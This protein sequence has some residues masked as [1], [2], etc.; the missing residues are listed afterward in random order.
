MSRF[1]MSAYIKT[2]KKA[3]LN[4]NVSDVKFVEDVFNP[5][6]EA[7]NVKDKTGAPLAL[8]KT[9]V[10]RLLA[11]KDDV[12][13]AMRNALAIFNLE[14][15]LEDGFDYLVKDVLDEN[16]ISAVIDLI[17]EIIK[18]DPVVSDEVKS[19]LDGLKNDTV[20]FLIYTFLEAVKIDNRVKTEKRIIWEKGNNS[21]EVISGDIFKF[22][23]G[24]RSVKKKN[25]VCIPVN[26]TFETKITT[27]T[28][29]EPKPLVSENTLHG[30]WLRHWMESGNTIKE[31]DKRIEGNIRLQE[32]EATGK[33][34]A[35]NGKELCYPIGSIVNIETN[36]AVYYLLAI[37]DF[38]K[39]NNARSEQEKIKTAL[40]KLLE[41]YDCKGQGYDLYLPLMGTGRSRAG[42]SH[43]ESFDL[44]KKVLLD[45]K[46]LIQGH[47]TIVAEPDVL[48]KLSV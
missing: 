29:K 8:D 4:E 3:A 31:L 32:L 14:E 28:E 20:Y 18:E 45:N 13:G 37:S 16:K 26:T 33:A 34:L 39:N 46:G 6:I 44:I 17:S 1:T 41:F 11:G 7:G 22:G 27:K 2:L 43:Q 15:G 40:E 9:R 23:F 21:V 5:L 10:S 19:K 38:D 12:P 47:I 25:I 48:E 42:L 35:G 24:N 36:N 30:K